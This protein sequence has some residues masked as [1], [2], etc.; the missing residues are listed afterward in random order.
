M[1]I[2]QWL[3]DQCHAGLHP[4]VLRFY[5]WAPAAISLG[6]HQQQ[7]PQHWRSLTYQ[8]QSIDL[9]R[10]PTGGRGVLHV[11]DLTYSLVLPGQSGQRRETYRYLCEFL[12]EGWQA[13]GVPL[14]FGT[15]GRGYHRQVSCFESAT[16]ADLVRPNGEKLIGSAQAWKG[17]TVLQHG[18]MQIQPDHHL[19]HQV[20]GT[21]LQTIPPFELPSVSDIIQALTAAAAQRFNADFMVQSLTPAEWAVIYSYLDS[22]LKSE[23]TQRQQAETAAESPQ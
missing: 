14:S 10:R 16:A 6:R 7:W 22:H 21:A 11:G 13:L 1:A 18:S 23:P 19:Q 15:A 3:F 12:I 9:V 20:F 4:P 5:E 2:D 17:Q 8:N